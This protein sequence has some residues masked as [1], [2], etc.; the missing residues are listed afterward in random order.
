MSLESVT[1][2]M[3]QI[4]SRAGNIGKTIKFVLE[5]GP[6]LI[7][8]TGEHP[9]ITNEDKEADLT[10]RTTAD[11]LRGVRDG[12]V[13]PMMAMMTGKLKISGDMALALQFQSLFSK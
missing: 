9:A 3:E 7:D 6:V 2:E 11:T 13:N 8:L 10:I 5:E 12:S 4:F 1:R